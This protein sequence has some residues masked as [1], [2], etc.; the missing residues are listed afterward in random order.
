MRACI[1]GARGGGRQR[2]A[3]KKITEDLVRRRRRHRRRCRRHRRL[4]VV[5]S[6]G[7]RNPACIRLPF[8]THVQPSAVRVA[9]CSFSFSVSLHNSVGAAIG[10][11]RPLTSRENRQDNK[12]RGEAGRQP[13]EKIR[14]GC[15]KREREETRGNERWRRRRGVGKR[16]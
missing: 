8:A 15:E 13:L 1:V 7:W 6:P 2:A 10:R 4:L 12:E 5:Q 9:P 3:T 11:R 16:W 14:K